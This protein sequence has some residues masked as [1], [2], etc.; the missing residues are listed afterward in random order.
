MNWRSA[1]SSVIAVIGT[2]RTFDASR[3]RRS[4]TSS[5]PVSMSRVAAKDA[6]RLGDE[7]GSD[8]PGASDMSSG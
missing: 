7:S 3:V 2:P 4:K 8:E 6:R 1:S 5:F